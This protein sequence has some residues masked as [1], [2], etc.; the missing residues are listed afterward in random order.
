[1]KSLISNY[2][3]V[4]LMVP[5]EQDAKTSLLLQSQVN[6]QHGSKIQD[7]RLHC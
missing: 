4:H 2:L 7:Q 5:A 3:Y 6:T 1:M